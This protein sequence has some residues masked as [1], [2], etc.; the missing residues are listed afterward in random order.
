MKRPSL[1]HL[2]QLLKL[3]VPVAI[4]AWLLANIDPEKW[5]QLQEQPK[6]WF[7]LAVAFIVAFSAVMI[8]FVSWYLLVRVVE[9]PI[10]L[11]EAVRLSFLGYLLNF[12]GAGSVGGDLFKAVFLAK[13]HRGRRTKAVASVLVDRVVGLYALLLVA[14]TALLISG[15]AARSSEFAILAK[16]VYLATVAGG[17]GIVLFMIPAFTSGRLAYK[18]TSIPKA[19]RLLAQVMNA[20]RIYRQR[21]LAM[22]LAVGMS[23]VVHAML[24]FSIWLAAVAVFDEVPTLGE[25]L[26]VVPVSLVVAALPVSPAGLG[27]FEFALNELYL[28]LTGPTGAPGVTVALLFRLMTIGV[29]TIGAV[30]YW[31]CRTEVKQIIDETSHQLD[32]SHGATD[33]ESKSESPRPD[34]VVQSS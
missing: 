18:L 14:S 23:I 32:E 27:T 11:T 20:L 5:A 25:H 29:A 19:G 15:V 10:S 24:A 26:V 16:L 9:V 13:D 3:V 6:N 31:T 1:R 21:G 4:I 7:L 30:F 28:L 2:I 12:V 33:D 17:I 8:S 22:L 34:L